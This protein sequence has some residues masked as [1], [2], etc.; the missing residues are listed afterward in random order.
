M[1]IM[2]RN[3]SDGHNAMREKR[4]EQLLMFYLKKKERKKIR[5]LTKY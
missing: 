4:K 1:I 5:K 2:S 3:T